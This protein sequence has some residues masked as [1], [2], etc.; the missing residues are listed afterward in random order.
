MTIPAM[1]PPES[2]EPPPLLPPPPEPVPVALELDDESVV[3]LAEVLGG[4]VTVSV[5]PGTERI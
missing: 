1:A 3:E 4:L 2:E 5:V